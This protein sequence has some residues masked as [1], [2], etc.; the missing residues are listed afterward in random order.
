MTQIFGYLS[1]A[2]IILSYIPYFISIFKHETRPERMSWLIWTMLG[3]IAF[4][5]QLA[6]GASDS[7]WLTGLDT[8]GEILV[9]IIAIKYGMGGIQKRDKQAFVIACISLILWYIT[10][11]PI[12]ALLLVIIADMTGA[13]LTI[14][15]TYAHP[16]TES[17]SAWVL[18]GLGGLC[19]AIAVGS[20]NWVLLLFP[21]YTMCQNS[22]ILMA[23]KLGRNR[24]LHHKKSLVLK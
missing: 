1:G 7:L 17:V 6:K 2:F 23:I 12:V 5:S 9:V 4:F 11:E 3:A 15:K 24:S 18:T 10:R 20:W 13:S 22:A 21:I 14:V 19:A 16:T 8:T